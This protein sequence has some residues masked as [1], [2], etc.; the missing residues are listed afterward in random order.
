MG[1]VKFDSTYMNESYIKNLTP[2]WF[3][4]LFNWYKPCN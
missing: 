2:T 4:I 3:Y 1:A